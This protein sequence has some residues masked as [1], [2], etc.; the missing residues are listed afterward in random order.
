[1][2]H[3]YSLLAT[4]GKVCLANARNPNHPLWLVWGTLLFFIALSGQ[5]NAQT[6]PAS[7]TVSGACL[8]NTY[9]LTK[10]AD[11]YEGTGRPAYSGTGTVSIGGTTYDGVAMAVFYEP[12]GPAWVLTFDG[13][14]YLSNPSTA[15]VP[16]TSGWV[17]VTTGVVGTCE[18]S[19]PVTVISGTVRI[20]PTAV[21]TICAGSP[22]SLT[23]T[24]TDLASPVT[25][26]WSSSPAGISGSGAIL[27]QNAPSVSGITTY[28]I[29]VTATSG[30]SSATASTQVVVKPSP[31]LTAGVKTNPTTCGGSDGSIAF[32]TTNVPNGSY[33]LTYTG[34]GSPRQITVSSN[35]FSLTGLSAGTYI[36]FSITYNGCTGSLATPITLTNPNA[37]GLTLSSS[38]PISCTAP[39]ATLTATSGFV[40]YS[41]SAGAT[42]QGGP[43]G[44]TATVSTAGVYSVSA[45][46]ANGC[47]AVNSVTVTGSSTPTPVDLTASS[48]ISCATP[49]VTLAATPGFVSYSFSAGATQQGGPAG[50]TASV[51]TAGTYSVTAVNANACTSTTMVTVTGS[52]TGQ[53]VDLV[54]SAPITCTAPTA[55]LTATAGFASYR[56]SAGASQQ[57][58][59]GGNTATVTL[60]GTYS[61]TATDANGCTSTTIVT[62][63]GS[64]TPPPVELSANGPV[65]CT[66]PTSTLTAT[67]G[68]IS[69]SFSAGATQQGG[70]GGNTATVTLAGTYS[71]SAVNATGCVS[72]TSVTVTGSST[73]TPVDL[74]ASSAISCA[75][76]TVTLAATPGFVSYSFSAGATQQGGPAGNT[77]SVST[78]GTYSVTAVNANACTSTT[79]VTVTGSS[80]GQPVDLVVSG[81]VPCTGAPVTLSATVGFASYS[82]S[83]GATQQGGSG[84][85]TATVLT[86]GVYSVTATDANACT[87]TTMVMV[88]PAPV[89]SI[90]P[91]STTICAGQQATLTATG[92]TG[93]LWSTGET[94][95]SI[96]VTASSSYSV[97][98]T[99]GSGCSATA[100]VTVNPLPGVSIN[101]VSP[102]I[103]AGQSVTLEASAGSSYVWSNA[104]TS[105]SISVG[106]AGPYSVTVT[107]ANGCSN[108]ATAMVT[109]NPLPVVS[110][111]AS[112]TAVSVGQSVTLTASGGDSYQWSTGD[113]GNRITVSAAEASTVYSVTV[114]NAAGCSQTASVTL[115]GVAVSGPN[116][117]CVKTAPPLDG[118]VTLPLTMTVVGASPA[119]TYSWS[120]KAAKSKNYKDIGPKGTSIG[121]VELEP[122]P[123]EPTLLITGTKGNLNS[124]QNNVIRLTVKLGNTVLGSF[125][126]LL[127]GSC[128][129]A[130]PNA[131]EGVITSEDVQVRVYPNP[132]A[133][134][135]QVE[136]RG[137]SK[138]A[139]VSLFDL[140]G[141]Q[142]GKWAVEPVE[143][144]GQL[145]TSVTN[146]SEGL[147][148]LQVETAEGVLHR[149]RVLKQR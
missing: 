24:P 64:S 98:L 124:L 123:G 4:G 129:L 29:T 112:A 130:I 70:A 32:T 147:Y 82:F 46:A 30:P 131:R 22:V 48:A 56:F 10:Y 138:P 35:T 27:T 42:Q 14:A 117:L 139:K 58:G 108:T 36:N 118:E 71:V 38:G 115:T 109:V 13:G 142:Q 120:Y 65:S 101:P 135:L 8:S 68:F 49:T 47:T 1:M 6:A 144:T 114:T 116:S 18:G 57:G 132:I 2:N 87:S 21:A 148:L 80:T 16:P 92:G 127:D 143:G 39:T 95:A 55:T 5:V 53:P 107:G 17:A 133:D 149:Q 77:A 105:Q 54:V 90:T 122:V 31:T 72:I 9:V 12:A 25:Y 52:S 78:A 85:N 146:L 121:K 26:A 19:A 103:C 128:P 34:A 69:Y 91:S 113:S 41:F 51:S 44:N 106:A 145:K 88:S 136:I 97:T 40:S 20:T 94:T 110:I 83:A 79:M 15:T 141:I 74:R 111:V 100:T 119:Y 84:G 7:I 86:A 89:V 76:P 126:T 33:T 59:S 73:P 104:A 93:Y 37:P 140:R 66:A 67:P 28:L 45:T 99:D 61:V 75:T 23:A 11:N 50:N 62:V 134:Q 96:S 137:L 81:P 63:S 102:T 43:A 60:A 125:E 3:K